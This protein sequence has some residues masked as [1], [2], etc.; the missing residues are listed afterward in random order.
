MEAPAAFVITA[1]SEMSDIELWKLKKSIQHLVATES[2]GTSM[3]TVVI[4]PGEQISK[5]GKLLTEEY[6]AATNIKSRVNRSSVQ[7]AIHS[8]QAKLKLIPRV[9]P[10]GVAIFCGEAQTEDGKM[11]KITEAIER[12]KHINFG[13]Y[14]C[15]K[16][17]EVK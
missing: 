2:S 6:G 13:L 12:P 1:V 17:F 8:A 10:N 16:K 15:G 14:K 3:I 9:P 4:S 7:T 5:S 11:R